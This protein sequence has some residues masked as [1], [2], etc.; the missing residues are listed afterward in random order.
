MPLIVAAG[1]MD[2]VFC[3]NVIIY[4]EHGGRISVKAMFDRIPGKLS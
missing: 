4:F 1:E 3:R 2:V